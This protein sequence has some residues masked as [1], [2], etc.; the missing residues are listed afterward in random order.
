MTRIT[1]S[2]IETLALELLEQQ[3]YEYIYAANNEI[4]HR[5]LMKYVPDC[6]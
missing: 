5:Y 4:F 6:Q 1:K 3:G 2:S